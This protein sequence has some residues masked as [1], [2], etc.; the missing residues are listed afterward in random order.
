LR[1]NSLAPI[2][3]ALF[4]LLLGAHLIIRQFRK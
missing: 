4:F 3:V 2:V 1:V